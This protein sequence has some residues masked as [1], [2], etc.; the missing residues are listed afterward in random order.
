MSVLIQSGSL[1]DIDESQIINTPEIRNAGT[2]QNTGT[3]NQ[4]AYHTNE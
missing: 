2:Y 1:A 3:V 4:S